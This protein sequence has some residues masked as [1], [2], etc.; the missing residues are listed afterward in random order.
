ML[1]IMAVIMLKMMISTM[2]PFVFD[3]FVNKNLM[4]HVVSPKRDFFFFWQIC[5]TLA[6]RCFI[7]VIALLYTIM[8]VLIL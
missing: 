2:L 1:P 3:Y 7:H 8:H 5:L 4:F 6:K